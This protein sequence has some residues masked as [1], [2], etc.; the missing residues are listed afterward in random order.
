M[1]TALN[2]TMVALL[3]NKSGDAVAQG[4]VVIVDATTASSFTTTTTAGYQSGSIGVVLEPNGIA[5]DAQGI[6]A[7]GGWV[8]KVNLSASADLGDLFAT[9]TVAKQAAAHAAPITGGD[10]GQVLGTGT[11]PAA[12]LWGQPAPPAAAGNVAADAIWDAAGDLAV[13]T[14]SNT[15]ARLAKGTAYQ[16]PRVKSDASTLEYASG[17]RVLLGTATPNGVNTLSFA[18]IP[19]IFNK[20]TVEGVCRSDRAAATADTLNVYLNNDTTATNYRRTTISAS[21]TNTV[22]AAGA[23]TSSIFSVPAVNSPAG[24]AAGVIFEIPDYAGTTFNKQVLSFGG[25]RKDDSTTYE[26]VNT[27]TME[28]ESTVAVNRVDLTLLVGNFVAGSTFRL[29]GEF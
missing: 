11:S 13:G 5:N 18:S 21:G 1:L 19:A 28:W 14:G 4:D 17:G 12:F 15:A 10:I 9:H 6:V 16:V 22:S 8:P 2:R 26:M 29:Y 3:T 7:F 24:S 20:I 25:F 23:D 27:G